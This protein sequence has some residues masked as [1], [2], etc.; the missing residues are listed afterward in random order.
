MLFVNGCKEPK[1]SSNRDFKCY[2]SPVTSSTPLVLVKI[3]P[4]V[5]LLMMPQQM[6]KSIGNDNGTNHIRQMANTC[7]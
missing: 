3:H 1:Y 7:H 2:Q 4:T 6:W 5:C